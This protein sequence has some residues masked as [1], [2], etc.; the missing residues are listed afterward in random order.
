MI[1]WSGHLQVESPKITFGDAAIW[2]VKA[3][4]LKQMI[5]SF[6]KKE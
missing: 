6:Y 5:D 1:W 3:S 4:F 2:D